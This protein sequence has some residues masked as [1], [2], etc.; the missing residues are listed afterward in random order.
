MSATESL[1]QLQREVIKFR[2]ERDWRQFHTP[3]QLAAALAIEA[4]EL[5][6][7]LLW[8]DDQQVAE[9]LKDPTGRVAIED[10]LADVFA[11]LL[12]LAE[13]CECRLSEALVR[14]LNKNRGKYPVDKAKGRADKYTAYRNAKENK[15]TA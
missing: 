13:V 2:D 14:K 12:C 9:K 7:Q 1:E 6:E 11:Y 15:T 5:Q 8:L 3:R 10:E 4:G